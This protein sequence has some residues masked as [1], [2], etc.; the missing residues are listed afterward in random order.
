ML[1]DD[2]GPKMGCCEVLALAFEEC[3]CLVKELVLCIEMDR[4]N[5]LG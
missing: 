5:I 4:D 2:A 1:M 3:F